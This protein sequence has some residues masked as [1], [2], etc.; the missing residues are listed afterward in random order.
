MIIYPSPLK[1]MIII[2]CHLNTCTISML[3]V[4][5][6]KITSQILV[7]QVHQDSLLTIM[8]E[9]LIVDNGV[10]FFFCNSANGYGSVNNTNM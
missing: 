8:S 5:D 4:L 3:L 9:V 1:L 2:S 7:Y 6:V 10:H